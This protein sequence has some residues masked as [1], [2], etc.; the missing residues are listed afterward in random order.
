MALKYAN[1]DL[2]I[3][4]SEYSSKKEEAKEHNK[5]PT[6]SSKATSP[7]VV[8]NATNY[9]AVKAIESAKLVVAIVG[10]KAFEIYG[11]FLSIKARQT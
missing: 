10:V 1:L 6:P 3:A 11:N 2:D 9:K 4:K 5:K 7:L 8:T